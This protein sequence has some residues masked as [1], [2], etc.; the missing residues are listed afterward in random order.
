MVALQ[1]NL[2]FLLYRAS[3]I[4]WNSTSLHDGWSD[5]VHKFWDSIFF[6][7][8]SSVTCHQI[9]LIYKANFQ[10]TQWNNPASLVI[11]SHYQPV[12]YRRGGFG[13][14]KP[15]P[16]KFRRFDK[17]EPNSQ[18]RGK[19]IRN[20]LTRIRLSLIFLSCF[21]KSPPRHLW[22]PTVVF[23]FSSPRHDVT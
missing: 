19:Y 22:P 18:F 3:L 11:N 21:V 10:W 16:P 1:Q 14:F 6:S 9:T 13:V 15:P 20:N 2:T 23:F 4:L 8:S 5:W 7:R 17:A 12:A